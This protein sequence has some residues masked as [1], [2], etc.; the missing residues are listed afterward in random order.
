MAA[1]SVL[2]RRYGD[3]G[4]GVAHGRCGLP[5]GRG[6]RREARD[7]LR[8]GRVLLGILN[9]ERLVRFGRV[10]RAGNLRRAVGGSG[11]RRNRSGPRH[12]LRDRRGGLGRRQAVALQGAVDAGIGEPHQAVGFAVGDLR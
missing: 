12:R 7:L 1:T 4:I 5:A 2:A 9:I 3:L 8:P 6:R 10:L 11:N